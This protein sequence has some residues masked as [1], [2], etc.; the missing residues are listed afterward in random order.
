MKDYQISRFCW[1]EFNM[2]NLRDNFLVLKKMV[3]PDVKIMPAIKVNAYS[4]GI[5]AC[6]KVLEE[7]GADYLGVGSIDEGILLRENGVNMPILIF[8]SNLIQETANLYVQYHLI[9]TILSLEAARSFSEAVSEPSD[10]FIKIDTGRGRIGVNAEEFPDFFR[11]VSQMPNL[12]VEGV[13]SHMAAVNWPDEGADYAV[14]QYSRFKAA[15]D[16]IGED[17]NR[18][19]FRQ[20]ANTPGCIA[21]PDIRMS[22]IC[23]GRAMWGYSP[24]TRRAEHP[25]LKAPLVSWKSCLVH[26]N[27]V[28]GGKFG[29][30]YKAVKMDTPK[31]IGIMVGGMGDGISP[32][33]AGGYVLL[34]GRK[35]PVASTVSLEH[36]IL[37]LTDFP[38]AK[39]GD[40]IVILGRQGE[41]EITLE[42]RMEEWGLTVPRIWT[43]I[44]AHLDRHYYRDGK[45]WAVAKDERFILNEN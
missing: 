24:L 38:D 45:L 8:A 9:P 36:T 39:P 2:D 22:G 44:S 31:R 7:C 17:A 20:L 15:M 3:G 37:D 19:P 18:I 29:E 40:E 21:L 1:L 42:Q 35:C 41:E 5:V 30:K 11:E 13:Y 32:K 10:V 23:P 33:I 28:T 34:H 25:E 43:E 4:H 16:A 6:G 27:E 12:H 26:V 14:W